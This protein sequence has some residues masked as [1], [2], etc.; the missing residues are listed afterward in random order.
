LLLFSRRWSMGVLERDT[1]DLS[2]RPARPAA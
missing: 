2:A 1:D